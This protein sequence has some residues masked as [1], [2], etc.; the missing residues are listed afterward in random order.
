ME[1]EVFLRCQTRISRLS[2]YF[3]SVYSFSLLGAGPGEG[4][5]SGGLGSL[6]V[7]QGKSENLNALCSLMAGRGAQWQ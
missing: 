5:V 1:M 7:S 4:A 3:F 6:G 2:A